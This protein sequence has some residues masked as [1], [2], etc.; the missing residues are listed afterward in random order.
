MSKWEVH[1]GIEWP[2]AKIELLFKNIQEGLE[3]ESSNSLIDLG[4]GGGW[5][6]LGLKPQVKDVIGLD[7]SF[8]MLKNAQMVFQ[9]K[10]QFICGD[11]GCLPIRP[12]SFDRVLCYF[13]FVNFSDPE[14]MTQ[15]ILETMRIL[16]KGGRALIGQIPDRA[17]SS[18]YDSAKKEYL[19]YCQKNFQVGKNIRD[20]CVVPVHPLDRK[21]FIQLLEKKGIRY[22]I[23]D[24]F[25]PFYRPGQ[26]ETVGWRFD[27]VLEKE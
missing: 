8:E 16:K 10:G 11:I 14:D 23:C 1:D 25:N 13:V 26:P 22:Q 12:G 7:I 4:C 19:E 24:S 5:I 17:H 15:A 21:F 27:L 6:G 18:Q 2:A 3:L 20:I 9:G